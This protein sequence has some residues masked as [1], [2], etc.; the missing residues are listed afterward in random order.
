MKDRLAVDT[1]RVEDMELVIH[2]TLRHQMGFIYEVDLATIQ[3][4]LPRGIQPVEAR[5]GVG[6]LFL[7]YNDYQ[8]GN[9]IGG[10]SQGRFHEVTRTVLVQ[11]DLSIRMPIPR[12]TFYLLRIGSENKAFVDQE[13]R[14]LHLPSY[15]SASLRGEANADGTEVRLLD[16]HGMIH[17]IKN[18]HPAPIYR[19]DSFFGQYY[20][21]EDG[22]LYFGVWSWRGIACVHQRSGDA[23]GIFEHPFLTEVEPSLAAGSVGR[24]YLQVFT[25]PGDLSEQRFYAPRFIRALA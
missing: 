9:L 10:Q 14:M 11:P 3:A 15:W 16:E 19:N 5:P 6:L 24:A 25:R 8:P 18:T 17:H 7:G 12:F 1:N 23:G 4:L 21:V 13:I 22:K 20:T 2:W